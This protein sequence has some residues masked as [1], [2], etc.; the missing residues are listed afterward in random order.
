MFPAAVRTVAEWYPKEERAQATGLFNTGSNMGAVTCPLIVPWLAS[1]FGWQAAFLVT[2]AVGFFWVA[3]WMWLY[4]APGEHPGVSAAELAH[5]RKDPLIPAS[6][7]RG[8]NCCDTARPGL[9]WPG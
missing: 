2:G 1:Q 4:P 7:F 9:L 3:A 8:G 6:R 5:I